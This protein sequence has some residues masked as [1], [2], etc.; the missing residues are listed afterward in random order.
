MQLAK[1]VRDVE[2]SQMIIKNKVLTI[3]RDVFEL[4]G[5]LPLETPIIERYETLAAKGGAEEDSDCLKETFK[6]QDQG[7]RNLALRFELTTSLARYLSCNPNT[8]LP[9]KRYEMGEV[10]RDGPIKL[11]RYRELWQCDI[12]TVGTNSM[13]ADAEIATMA[14]AFFTQANLDVYFK[15]NNRKL[16]DGILE[17]AGI[18]ETKEAII[19]I[20]KLDKIFEKGVRE[21]LLTR[22]YTQK[23]C[24]G[25]FEL[26]RDG[27]SL[28][29]LKEKI[30]SEKGKEG[31]SELE[32][33]FT[34]LKAQG[35]TN[36]KFD[37]SLA[38][39]QAYYTGT[40][41]EAYLKNPAEKEPKG[42][43]AGGG[44]YDDMVGKFIGGGRNVPAVG[45][46]F[47]LEPIMDVLTNR[48]E[49]TLKST[50]KILVIP[51]NTISD[52]LAIT[53][54]LRRQ[55]IP[56]EIAMG[57]KGISK[58]LEYAASLNIPFVAIVGEDELKA[59]K[60]KLRNMISGSEELLT[61]AEL[62][63]ELK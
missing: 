25:I 47:G 53:E 36:Y 52:C 24:D 51:I 58:N 28:S 8:K 46:S 32:E 63:K 59:K 3:M 14:N 4:Y 57:K 6:F 34:Y 61:V 50:T 45:I 16:L 31:I 30:T 17:Q 20:D 43:L 40:V 19:S 56:S 35:I 27:I 26:I 54:Q 55:G 15:I 60:I 9:F 11:G 41:M 5:F 7:K 37:V 48:D 33:L 49:G 1:G 22:G 39:G 21:E 42:S 23:Q 12:D 38:R 10:F 29:E 18:K 62:I 2:P 44:R 13:L